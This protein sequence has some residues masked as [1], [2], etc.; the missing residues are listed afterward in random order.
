MNY[1]SSFIPGFSFIFCLSELEL[2]KQKGELRK[3]CS[4]FGHAIQPRRRVNTT[5]RLSELRNLM[6]SEVHL[7]TLPVQAYLVTSHDEHQVGRYKST[8]HIY[9]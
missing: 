9:P 6:V 2:A 3:A 4:K 1:F 5:L 8:K 7:G